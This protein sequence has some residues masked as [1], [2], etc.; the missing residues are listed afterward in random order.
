[1]AYH[2][3]LAL[4][5]SLEPTLQATQPAALDL[6]TTFLSHPTILVFDSPFQLDA[7]PAA[8]PPEKTSCM[9]YG[10]P[11]PSDMG[12]FLECLVLSKTGQPYVLVLSPLH[13]THFTPRWGQG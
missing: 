13:L 9:V 8:L 5:C 6:I 4:V 2:F 1:M 11:T 7:A 10:S 12:T 3:K